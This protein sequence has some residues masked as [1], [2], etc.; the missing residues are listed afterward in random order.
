MNWEGTYGKKK[1]LLNAAV[2][3]CCVEKHGPMGGRLFNASKSKETPSINGLCAQGPTHK[4]LMAAGPVGLLFICM[5]VPFPPSLVIRRAPR[6][7]GPEAHFAMPHTYPFFLLLL[8]FF[9]S[10]FLPLF[11]N[12]KRRESARPTL[13]R[14]RRGLMPLGRPEG[15]ALAH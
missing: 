7:V 15:P 2:K 6:Q 9:F 5:A 12:R 13:I 8:S 14:K 11:S 1:L 4:S 10:F 3:I